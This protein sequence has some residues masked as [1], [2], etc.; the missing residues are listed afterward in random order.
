[1]RKINK[2]FICLLFIVLFNLKLTSSADTLKINDFNLD[3]INELGQSK[4]KLVLEWNMLE[5]LDEF[6]VMIKLANG[7]KELSYVRSYTNGRDNLGKY[8]LSINS[9]G[10]YHYLLEFEI[11]VVRTG[12][13]NVE[14]K[15]K[16]NDTWYEYRNYIIA[17]G[18]VVDTKYFTKGKAVLVGV[19]ISIF[20]IIGSLLIF[21]SSKNEYELSDDQM[22]I[23]KIDKK[24]DK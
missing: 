3:V 17:K 4:T 24:V 21:E 22:T 20:T 15:Y 2:V 23:T 8:Q 9:D 19:I 1:M 14:I 7:Q 18:Q 13:F 6:E 11:D 16:V 10:S 5:E 12:S